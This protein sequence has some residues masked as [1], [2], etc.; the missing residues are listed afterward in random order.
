MACIIRKEGWDLNP[1]DDI[2]N[3]ILRRCEANDGFCPCVHNT[4]NYEGKDLFCPCTDYLKKD[5]CICG[6]YVKTKENND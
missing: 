5:N 4:D 1:N 2:V 3:S 6:L